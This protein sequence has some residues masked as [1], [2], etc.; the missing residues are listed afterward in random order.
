MHFAW[1]AMTKKQGSAKHLP[2][3]GPFVLRCGHEAG[4]RRRH[5]LARKRAAATTALLK[6]MRALGAP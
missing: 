1:L 4:E 2:A 6:R 5:D 3:L